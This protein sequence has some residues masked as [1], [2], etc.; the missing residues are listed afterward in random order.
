[1]PRPF[2]MSC[3]WRSRVRAGTKVS[4]RSSEGLAEEA[5]SSGWEQLSVD[6]SDRHLIGSNT[7]EL[8]AGGRRG[9]LMSMVLFGLSA[10]QMAKADDSPQA[11]LTGLS[12]QHADTAP[13]PLEVFSDAKD[14]FTMLRPAVWK[15]VDKPG[16]TVFFEDPE[17]RGNNIGVTVNPVRIASLKA[18]GTVDDV[19]EKLIQAERDKPSTKDMQVIR[20]Q[21][22]QLLKDTPLYTLEYTLDTS[23]GSKRV[24]T[25]VTVSGYKLYILSI[26]YVDGA[27]SPAPVDV[28]DA[29]HKVL[30]SFELLA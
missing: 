18:F 3:D 28:D 29:L 20:V 15:K 16:A 25:A 22:K 8:V 11:V 17:I 19:T 7:D 24:L 30:N 26:V 10:A 12:R 4:V 2:G 27:K 13:L 1:M 5:D 23:R 6:C 21:E 9:V 14:G